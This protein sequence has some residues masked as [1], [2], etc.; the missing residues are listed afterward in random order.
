MSTLVGPD[1]VS[2]L[3]KGEVMSHPLKGICLYVKSNGNP[4]RLYGERL[5]VLHLQMPT[6][7]K[8]TDGLQVWKQADDLRGC[9]KD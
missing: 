2:E 6:V 3:G 8:D 9:S 4:Q 7:M 5:P 1:E